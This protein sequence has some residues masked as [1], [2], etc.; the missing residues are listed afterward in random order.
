MNNT[1]K[2]VNLKVVK[3]SAVKRPNRRKN[4]ELSVTD[5]LKVA[6]R[7]PVALVMGLFA[8]Y[9]PLAIYEIAHHDM[10]PTLWKRTI[11]WTIVAGGLIFS[12]KTVYDWGKQMFCLPVK[13]GG[14]VILL[15]GVMIS[16]S[17]LPVGIQ[18]LAV[19]ALV[20]LMFV[21]AIS[22]AYNLSNT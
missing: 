16:S 19:I 15:E 18:W 17:I 5:Q 1:A 6:L 11:L 9:V 4:K 14:F 21:N 2:K 20:I 12:A 22:T 8:G 7:N 3:D 10:D 13:A